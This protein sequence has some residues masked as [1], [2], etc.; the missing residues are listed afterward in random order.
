[1]CLGFNK[2]TGEVSLSNPNSAGRFL[3]FFTKCLINMSGTGYLIETGVPVSPIVYNSFLV[4]WLNVGFR[5][6]S[7]GRRRID[8]LETLHLPLPTN[9]DPF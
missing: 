9:Q 1:M 4:W 8:L 3:F 2:K 6:R 7:V 5:R